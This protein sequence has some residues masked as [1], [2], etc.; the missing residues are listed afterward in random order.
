MV[1]GLV[2][3]NYAYIDCA[4]MEVIGFCLV[5]PHTK[6]CLGQWLSNNRGRQ[7]CSLLSSDADGD[8]LSVKLELLAVISTNF[9][10]KIEVAVVKG[11]GDV[12]GKALVV[13]SIGTQITCR[14]HG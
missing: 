7:V 13:K 1:Y 2:A 6:S 10:I 9:I 14:P 5:S 12:V 8:T 4:P 3:L 11:R